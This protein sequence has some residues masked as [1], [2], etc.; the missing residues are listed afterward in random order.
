MVVGVK[1]PISKCRRSTLRKRCIMRMRPATVS[2]LIA[3]AA[4]LLSLV[5]WGG[6][7]IS[8]ESAPVARGAAY[9]Q[10]RGCIGCHGDP[11]NPLA[12]ANDVGCSNVNNTSWHP[13]YDAE[14]RDA[15]AYF[16]TV[17]LRR[18]FADRAQFDVHNPLFAGEQLA[19][20]Y[21]CFQCHG[22]L[23]QGGFKNSKSLKGYVPGY[24]GS[25]FRV[26]T[27]NADPESVRAWIEHGM[28]SAILEKPLTGRIAGFFFRRQAV[29]MP[30]YKSLPP[31]EI[32]ILVNY[33]IALNEFGPMTAQSV[34]SYGERSRSTGGL[35]SSDNS[36]PSKPLHPPTRPR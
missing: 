15:M 18:N 9:A 6:Y 5:A 13:K 34:R 17:R 8:P 1:A 20:Q 24:F 10:V 7:R 16:E 36:I 14:C 4:T 27:R 12:D 2:I 23:G 28:D 32:D 29:S 21:H 30:S 33:V 26:L 11:A 25:D 22:H 3:S 31:E 19:R 35:V